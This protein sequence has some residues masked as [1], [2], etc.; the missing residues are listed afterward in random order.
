MDKAEKAVAEKAAAAAAI[1]KAE[2]AAEE[3]KEATEKA[4]AAFYEMRTAIA[5]RDG[6]SP[7]ES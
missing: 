7:P 1:V 4:T 3:L 6:R 2:A 5:V